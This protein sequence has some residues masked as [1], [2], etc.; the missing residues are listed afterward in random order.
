MFSKSA[1]VGFAL[2]TVAT[3]S[4][5]GASSTDDQQSATTLNPAVIA[6]GFAQDGQ[7][8]P[9]EG[10]VPSLTSTNNFINFCLTVNKPITNGKQVQAG[11]CNPAPMGVIAA[12]T[13]MPS[14]KFVFPKN[15]DTIPANQAFTIKMAINHLESGNFVNAA[16]NYFSAPQQVNSGGDIVGHSHVVVDFLDSLDQTKP[17]TP[18]TFAFFK[19]LNAPADNGILTADVDK[20]LPAGAYRLASI[21]SAANHQPVLVAVA[22]HGSLDDMVYFTVE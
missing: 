5:L 9:T 6:T 19:G 22:Q 7:Q 10:Q 20:G 15:N 18:G 2:L 3:S 16:T 8:D 12:R 11:S 17:T 21:N 1:F 13:N 4:V 14:S